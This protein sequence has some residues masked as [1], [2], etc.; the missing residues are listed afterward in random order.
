MTS[1]EWRPGSFTKNFSWGSPEYG[2]RVLHEMIRVGFNGNL[3]DVPRS[4]F[5]DRVQGS[6]RPDYIALNFFLFNKSVGGVDHIIADELVFQALTSEHSPRFDKLALFA[7]N[8]SYV[9][10]WKGAAPYQRRPAL[11][12]FHYV[13]DKVR[14]A[15][16]W[17]TSRVTADDIEF[18]IKN[19]PRYTGATTRKL[20]TNLK[21]LYSIGR[22]S[23]FASQKVER[24]WVDALFLALDRI[25]ED[26]A[27][28]GKTTTES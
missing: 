24:W 12:A 14:K 18:F 5:R 9:G 13:A 10:H 16:S 17:D 26:R 23:E 3:E 19:D 15:Y 11:W 21:Y 22:L 7:F 27:A 2:L 6:D 25:I 1:E 20:A 4:Q 8:F 28:H